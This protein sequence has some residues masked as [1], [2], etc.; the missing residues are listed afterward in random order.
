MKKFEQV[1]SQY[2]MNQFYDSD[3]GAFYA[4]INKSKEDI[5]TD[6]KF[7]SDLS[8]AIICYSELD[9]KNEVIKLIADMESFSDSQ[10]IGYHELL[11]SSNCI[12]NVG[13]VRTVKTQLLAAYSMVC[14]GN[15]TDDLMLQKKGYELIKYI[16]KKFVDYNYPSVLT[17]DWKDIINKNILVSDVSIAIIVSLKSDII[18]WNDELLSILKKFEDAEGAVF[19]IL[20]PEEESLKEYGKSLE[21]IAAY[22][23]AL[24]ELYNKYGTQDYLTKNNNLFEFVDIHMRHSL[25]GGFWNR[26]NADNVPSMDGI[27]AYYRNLPA[28]P[29]KSSTSEAMLLVALKVHLGNVKAGKMLLELKEELEHEIK[30]YYD[31]RNGGLNLGKGCWFASA[32]EPTVPLARQTTVPPHTLGSFYVGNTNYVP[33]QQ[34]Q[35]ATQIVALYALRGLDYINEK[36]YEKVSYNIHELE[37]NDYIVKGPLTCSYIDTNN[38][39]KWLKKTKS[40]AGYGLTAYKSPL[41][42]RADKSPQN[43]SALHVVSDLTVLNERIEGKEETLQSI[44]SGQNSD[45]GFGEQPSLLSEVFTT[46]CVVLTSYILGKAV[47]NIKKCIEYVQACQNSDGGF[48]NAPGYPSD[49]W[50]TNLA[51]LSLHIW[52]ELPLDFAGAVS[53]L[54]CCMNADGGY[55]VIPG[56]KSD[57]YSTFRAIS[58]LIV[59]E[60]E[61]TDKEKTIE[62][63]QDRQS[64]EGGFIYQ[65]GKTHSFVGTYHAIAALYLLGEVPKYLEECKKWLAAHQMKDGGFSRTISGPSDTTDEGF[66]VIQASFMLEKLLNPYWVAIVT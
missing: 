30:D 27:G 29:Y 42:F 54:K 33:L 61:I 51:V 40:G 62:W 28:Y 48:G 15:I 31:F 53:F 41:G 45:G 36:K 32:T 17:G 2:I 3:L 56:K 23:L 21:D 20:S 13:K 16:L 14:A 4:S 59:L 18:E 10:N 65:E 55:G 11:D 7:L 8:S 47:Y 44:S 64:S 6:D 38:Y 60:I 46:Y 22:S 26:C 1:L 34:K 5:V 9:L 66:I 63:L 39:V 35:M 49:V 24:S 12:H 37:K 43:F 52:G 57:T 25:L 50:H 58:S 19:S